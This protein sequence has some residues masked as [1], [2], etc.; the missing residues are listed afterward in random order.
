MASIDLGDVFETATSHGLLYVQL[1]HRHDDYGELIRVLA[2]TR[3]Q[4]P[5]DVA[6]VAAGPD[7]WRGFYPLRAA[8][9]QGLMTPVGRAVVPPERASFPTFKTGQRDPRTGEVAQWWL[10]DGDREWR[11]DGLDPAMQELPDRGIFNHEALLWE[12]FGYPEDAPDGGAESEPQAVHYLYFGD[13]TSA[14]RAVSDA[15]GEAV[16]SGAADDTWVVKVRGPADVDGVHELE[17]RLVSVAERHGGEY[18]GHEVSN[19]Q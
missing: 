13:E 19:L 5:H 18:D 7:V 2:G 15:G 17:L 9:N 14:R 4:R 11:V 3:D 12:V 10:W 8:V 1:T 16:P 6:A